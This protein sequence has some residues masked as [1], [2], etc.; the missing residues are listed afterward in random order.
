MDG[1]VTLLDESYNAN[2]ASMRAALAVLASSAPS[3]GMGRFTRGRRL[4]FLGDMLELGP[5]EA[6]FHAALAELPEI[7]AIDRVHCCGPR[8][9]ALHAALPRPKRGHWCPDSAALAAEVAKAVDAGDVVMVKGSLGARMA[10][11]V[12]AVRALGSA[13]PEPAFPS[14]EDA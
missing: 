1:A 7:A 13:V 2:P 5:D 3:D 6:A 8:M 9:Q 4:A 14:G 10:R 12:E 11:V